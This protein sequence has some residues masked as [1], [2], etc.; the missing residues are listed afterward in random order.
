LKITI[1]S[2]KGE[3]KTPKG[4]LEVQIHCETSNKLR[5]R[6]AV[7]VKKGGDHRNKEE[8]KLVNPAG[9]VNFSPQGH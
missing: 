6:Q 3:E 4:V 8:E 7:V 1:K 9:S 5:K 2:R